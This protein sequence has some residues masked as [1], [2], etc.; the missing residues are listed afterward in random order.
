M[1][2]G[3]SGLHLHCCT[4]QARNS[5]RLRHLKRLE[6]RRLSLEFLSKR[7]GTSSSDDLRF[8]W[9]WARCPHSSAFGGVLWPALALGVLLASIFVQPERSFSEPEHARLPNWV[10]RSLQQIRFISPTQSQPTDLSRALLRFA[11]LPL[12]NLVARL[13][14][15]R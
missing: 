7:R 8:A 6:P 10:R 11:T 3:L 2:S 12:E 9:L 13:K 4:R 5:Q 1:L 14:S 15:Y